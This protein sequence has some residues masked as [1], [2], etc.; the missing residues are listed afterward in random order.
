MRVLFERSV[1]V[2]KPQ[3]PCHPEM[4][5]EKNL[6]LEVDEDVLPAASHA[7]DAPA[8]H[9]VDEDLRLGMPHDRRKQKVAAD[10]GAAREVRPQVTDD[11]F[12]FR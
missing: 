1:R 6:I 3:L 12:Y 11:R 7:R 4:D 9:A 10:D 5:D 8:R 2:D